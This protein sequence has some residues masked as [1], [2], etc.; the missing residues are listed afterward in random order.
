MKEV[1]R[2]FSMEATGSFHR[3]VPAQYFGNSVAWCISRELLTLLE[4]IGFCT[5]YRV[6]LGGQLRG[7]SV[8]FVVRI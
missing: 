8:L 5:F 7:G 4:K 3:S 2:K 6:D 1:I